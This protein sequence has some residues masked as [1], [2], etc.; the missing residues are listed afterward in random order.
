MCFNAYF[1]RDII[2][3][4]LCK[5]RAKA[6]R[7]RHNKYYLATKTHLKPEGEIYQIMP[8]RRM[9]CKFRFKKDNKVDSIKYTAKILYRAIKKTEE[10]LEN[11]PSE[12]PPEWFNK[13]NLF[14]NNVTAKI[15]SDYNL[16]K[17]CVYLIQKDKT[18]TEYRPLSRYVLTEKVIISV[19]AKYFADVFDNLFFD[20]SYAFRSTKNKDELSRK[21]HHKT[22]PII[23]K[24]RQDNNANL[25]V[26]ECDIRKFYDCVN[27][28]LIR[29][30]FWQFRTTEKISRYHS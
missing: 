26:A 14:I 9:W 7:N 29:K 5:Y 20:C 8:P 6:A 13:L 11:N 22:I 1:T 12:K 18:R 15:N 28:K 19:A 27:H 3:E 21:N 16:A 24:Y 2:I 17:P 23:Q 30:T 10:K 4:L 25:W